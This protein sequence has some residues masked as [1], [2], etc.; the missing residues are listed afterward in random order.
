MN[1][2]RVENGEIVTCGATMLIEDVREDIVQ[3]LLEANKGEFKMSPQSGVGLQRMNAAP[4]EMS[5]TIKM[6]LAENMK[7]NLIAWKSMT[8]IDGTIDIVLSEE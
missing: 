5:Q 8:M 7:R 2:I 4:Q 6:D 1:G 3:R